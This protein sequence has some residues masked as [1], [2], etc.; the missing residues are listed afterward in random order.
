MYLFEDE[1]ARRA[2]PTLLPRLIVGKP[3]PVRDLRWVGHIWTAED[4][5]KMLF[6]NGSH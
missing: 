1:A 5:S 4:G 3:P 2:W 6:F